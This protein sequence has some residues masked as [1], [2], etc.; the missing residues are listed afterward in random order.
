MQY[1]CITTNPFGRPPWSLGQGD[2]VHSY[3]LLHAGVETECDL[4]KFCTM[5]DF[6]PLQ[7][8]HKAWEVDVQGR[9]S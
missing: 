2:S 3:W 1:E 8:L 9:N 6:D 4:E 5:E 7:A